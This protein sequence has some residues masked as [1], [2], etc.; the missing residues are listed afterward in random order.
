MKPHFYLQ[1]VHKQR[2]IVSTWV[3][4]VHTSRAEIV[5]QYIYLG[6]LQT[7]VHFFGGPATKRGGGKVRARPLRKNNFFWNSKKIPKN[8]TTKLEGGPSKALVAR[9]TNIL[10]LR[11]WTDGSRDARCFHQSRH[12]QGPQQC[13][14]T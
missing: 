3:I 6:K 10:F 11:Q 12:R 14:R 5:I 2:T 4:I 13:E 9:P 1:I 7:K 8:V